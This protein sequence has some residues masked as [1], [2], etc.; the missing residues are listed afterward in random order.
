MRIKVI[1]P[2]KEDLRKDEKEILDVFRSIQEGCIDK[3]VE[4]LKTI[5]TNTACLTH[6]SGKKQSIDEFLYELDNGTLNY[7]KSELCD[8]YTITVDGDFCLMAGVLIL[9][10]KV[11]GNS[12]IWQLKMNRT[13]RNIDNKWYS[14]REVYSI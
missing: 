5:Y 4:Y 14:D 2:V 9:D 7:F 1:V 11:Y 10:A 13:F 8:N 3:N 6:I 12:G